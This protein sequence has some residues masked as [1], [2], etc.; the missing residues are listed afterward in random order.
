LDSQVAERVILFLC[1][2]GLMIRMKISDK[3]KP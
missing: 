2:P 3:N 1:I